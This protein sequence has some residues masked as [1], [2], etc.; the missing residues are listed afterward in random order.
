MVAGSKNRREAKRWKYVSQILLTLDDSTTCDGKVSSISKSGIL[1]QSAHEFDS[2]NIVHIHWNDSQVGN[3]QGSFSIRTKRKSA[4]TGLFEYRARYYKVDDVSKKSILQVLQNLQSLQSSNQNLDTTFLKET[5]SQG[6]S[7]FRAYQ[8]PSVEL[9]TSIKS[10][11]ENIP[12]LALQKIYQPQSQFDFALRKMELYHIHLSLT[13]AV[14][15]HCTSMT[16][17]DFLYCLSLIKSLLE[18]YLIVEN[19]DH[20]SV[21][22]E[23]ESA[24]QKREKL[25]LIF[26]SLSNSIFSVAKSLIQDLEEKNWLSKVELGQDESADTLHQQSE[27]LI[28]YFRQNIDVSSEHISDMDMILTRSAYEVENLEPKKEEVEKKAA[29]GSREKQRQEDIKR[30]KQSVVLG[31]LGLVFLFLLKG[32]LFHT[33]VR[34]KYIN[35]LDLPEM[36][37]TKIHRFGDHMSIYVKSKDGS[38]LLKGS[39]LVEGAIPALDEF[40]F[41]QSLNTLILYDKKKRFLL[42][43]T[44][45]E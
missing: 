38:T 8:D 35:Q 25:N 31:I 7:I 33:N 24:Q 32:E 20:T 3:I 34:S 16:K 13:Y 29:P 9:N 17:D 21:N 5:V 12:E 22:E 11:L 1:F 4:E 39:E 26:K 40:L 19:E 27:E 18:N 23:D 36:K 28:A 2:G 15:H 44:K 42:I 45:K 30:L 41:S 10:L 6:A 43:R 14:L 37:I